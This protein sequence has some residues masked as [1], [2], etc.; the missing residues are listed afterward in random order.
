MKKTIILLLACLLLMCTSAYADDELKVITM[1]YEFIS[2]SSDFIYPA[3]EYIIQDDVE[4]ILQNIEYEVIKKS[5]VYETKT[6]E[7]K[8]EVK[9]EGVRNQDEVDFNDYMS[10]HEDGYIG[11]IGLSD[12]ASE[13]R[14]ITGRTASQ[15]ICCNFGYQAQEPKPDNEVKT[16]YYDEETECDVLVKLPFNRLKILSGPEWKGTVNCECIHRSIYD[17][18]YLLNDGTQLRYDSNKPEFKDY[19]YIILTQLGLSVDT[20][21]ITDGKWLD[22]ISTND[23]LTIRKAEYIIERLETKYQAVY[24]GSFDIPD[25]T[26]LD[27]TAMYKGTLSKEVFKGYEFKVK[28]IAYYEEVPKK[29]NIPA[30]VAGTGSGII[31]L[32]GLIVFLKKRKKKGITN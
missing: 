23:D 2:Q 26:V 9:T 1:E 11:T 20:H 31:A 4:Y 25:M 29:S 7:F 18:V 19:E 10:I 24:S 32:C 3:D 16:L 21:R 12:I 6:Q 8:R 17:D 5:P 14:V 13:E 30:V 15:V 27:I 22:D 28:A